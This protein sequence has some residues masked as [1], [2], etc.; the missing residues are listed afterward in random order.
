MPVS[1]T[2]GLAVSLVAMSWAQRARDTPSAL[3]L[4]TQLAG[5]LLYPF[6]EGTRE[7]RAAFSV[8]GIAVL[9]LAVLAV[10]RTPSFTWV[11]IALG[12]PAVVLLIAQIFSSEAWLVP[13]SAAFEAA[14][15]F[16][17][18]VALIRYMFADNKVTTD[19]L[20]A[21]GATFTLVAWAFAYVYVI[22]QYLEPGSYIAAVES[23]SPRSWVELLYLSFTTLTST[24]LSDV[25]P[26]KPFAR[27]VLMIEQLAGVLYI[28]MVIT[29]LIGLSSVRR[30]ERSARQDDRG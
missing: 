11:S 12:V 23:Q 27:S 17:A 16:Y 8:L 21:V 13:C 10:R 6:M 2:A 24:G 5:V 22:V 4:F 18:A 26:V 3:L 14:L 9:A 7:G 20:F 19:E 1:V 29:R 28:A 30:R 15:Y 25:V